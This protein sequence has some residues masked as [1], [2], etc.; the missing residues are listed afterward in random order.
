MRHN[1]ITLAT[2]F[3]VLLTF[4]GAGTADAGGVLPSPR[5]QGN[6]TGQQATQPN[7]QGAASA[8]VI[9]QLT[10]TPLA[11]NTTLNRGQ[12]KRVDLGSANTRS[13]RA[14]L[15]A[16]RNTFKQWLNKSAPAAKITSEFDISLNAVGVALNGAS[17]DLVRTGPG[18]VSVEYQQTYTPLIAAPVDPDLALIDAVNGWGGGGAAGAGYGI[19]VAVIDSGI[20]MTHPC[21][22]DGRV[23]VNKVFNNRAKLLNLGPEPGP[24]QDHGT[25]VAGTIA[26][27]AGTTLTVDGVTLP[28]SMSG[29]APAAKLGNYNVFPGPFENARSEDILNALEAAYADGMDIANM[30]LGGGSNGKQDLVTHAVDVLDAGGMVIAI[31]AGNSGQS[32][33]GQDQY[34]SIGSPGMA[35]RALTAGAYSVGHFV[36]I[37]VDIGV[38]TVGA[39]NGDFPAP[40]SPLTASLAVV[41]DGSNFGTGCA[42]ISTDVAG[43][44]AVVTRGVCTF[45]QKVANAEAAGAVAVIVRNNRAGVPTAMATDPAYPSTIPAVMVALAAGQLLKD[46]DGN[47]ATIGTTRV[48]KHIDF[49]DKLIMY[50][51]SKGPTDVDF[52]VKPDVVAPGGNVLSSVLGGG[53]AFFSGTSMASPHL[54]GMAAVVKSQ[55]SDWSAFQVRSAIVNTASLTG[56]QNVLGT[57]AM[58]NPLV[59]GNG[60]VSLTAAVGAQVALDSVSTNFGA[61]PVGNGNTWTK[62]VNVSYLNG[63]SGTIGC[64]VRGDGYGCTANGSRLT[65]TY[66]PRIAGPGPNPGRLIVTLNAN[67]VATSVLF[68]WGK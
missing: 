66:T 54:A 8:D 11:A 46:N 53:F 39:V 37:G 12:T 27:K 48:Y 61:I 16:I 21:F 65:I 13:A 51:S 58:T 55:H 7:S 52:R 5:G 1:R 47:P 50:F 28:Y 67:L 35:E 42:P 23:I 22:S 6:A 36:G 31:S 38:D 14:Q 29:V 62:T 20:D 30:S 15:A 45:S 10:G 3:L 63:S 41:W 32:A 34:F 57:A 26:C 19:K 4:A 44:I 18:V 49:Y 43:K 9:V 64:A 2:A 60:G 59:V 40:S 24:G 56:L 68:A 33:S 17:I 25:H